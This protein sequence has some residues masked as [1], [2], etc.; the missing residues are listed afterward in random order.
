MLKALQPPAAANSFSCFG[1]TL[2]HFSLYSKAMTPDTNKV[3]EFRES[4]SSSE[5]CLCTACS[6]EEF[7]SIGKGKAKEFLQADT[8]L[9]H[10]YGLPFGD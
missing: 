6:K 9:N 5:G 1:N 8:I 4:V 3:I 10:G 7:H 2:E